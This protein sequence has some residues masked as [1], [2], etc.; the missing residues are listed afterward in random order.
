M[1]DCLARFDVFTSG[2]PFD[3]FVRAVASI[4]DAEADAHFRSQYT[5]VADSRGDVAVDFVGRYEHLAE[6]FEL[7]RRTIGM[8][9]MELPRLVAARRAVHYAAYYTSATR[10]IVAERFRRD[11]AV[12][13]RLRCLTAGTVGV[14]A[15]SP[16]RV[17]VAARLRTWRGGLQ[18]AQ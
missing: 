15:P 17:D 14:A 12:R 1:A 9:Q 7:V 11:T 5:F 4:P 13:L 10:E 18:V 8:P 16:R 6:D 2:M 3:A